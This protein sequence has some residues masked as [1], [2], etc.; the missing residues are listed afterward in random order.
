MTLLERLALATGPSREL[1]AEIAR[2]LGWM[3]VDPIKGHG[4]RP[5]IGGGFVWDALPHFT[6][7]IDAAITLM[8]KEP[9]HT[10]GTWDWK[11]EIANGGLTIR[12]QVG[13]DISVF[14]ETPALA[15]CSAAIQA[16]LT[17]RT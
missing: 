1:D 6:G 8:P 14:G 4:D 12:A 7:S 9:E 17:E 10:T 11:L 16:I 5:V 15:L 2:A 3:G 13:P